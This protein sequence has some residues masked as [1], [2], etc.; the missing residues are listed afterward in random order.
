MLSF[1]EVSTS[2]YYEATGTEKFKGCIDRSRDRSCKGDPSGTLSFTFRYWGLFGSEDPESIVWGSCWHPVVERDG[3]LRRRAGRADVRRLAVQ[4]RLEDRLHRQPHARGREGFAARR[5][6]AQPE[7]D[8]RRRQPAAERG[9]WPRRRLQSRPRSCRLARTSAMNLDTYPPGRRSRATASRSCS[10]A[11]AWARST[12]RSTCASAARSRSSCSRRRR[13]RRAAARAAA[14]RVAARRRPRSPQRDPDL[15]GRRGRRAAVHR[16]A[17][18]PGRRP[19]GAVA[20]RGSARSGARD[21]DRGPG[22]RRAGC[23]AP[24]RPCAPR[25]QAEQRPARPPGR[26]RALLPGGLRPDPERVRAGPGGR[27]V[28]GHD[29][30]RLARADPRRAA[31]RPRRPVRPR[32]SA[33]RVPDGHRPLSP[34]LG[35]RG[36]LRPPGGAGSGRVG[37]R[38]RAAAALDAVLARGMAKRPDERYESCAALVGAARQAL[39]LGAAASAAAPAHA[40]ARRRRRCSPRRPRSSRCC[41]AADARAA[42]ADGRARASRRAVRTRSRRVRPSPAIRAS[43][44]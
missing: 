14:A 4:A 43:W 35:R 8:P 3:R 9:P 44:R 33:V 28:H 20:A 38:A 7:R 32:L 10:G 26:P 15:R 41:L 30:L 6:A 18:R 1:E 42:A 5:L 25:R 27:P 29:R 31:R 37:A 13:R 23:R 17:L 16:D 11:A 34:A 22:R 36:D 12:G 24:A 40:R 2:P 21:R 39:G 19:Q